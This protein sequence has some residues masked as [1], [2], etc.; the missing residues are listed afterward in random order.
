MAAASTAAPAVL[1]IPK[2]HLVPP[3]DDHRAVYPLIIGRGAF[4]VVYKA[5]YIGGIEPI[6][7]AVKK[8]LLSGSDMDAQCLAELKREGAIMS[9]T[10][11]P[12]I[13][14]CYGVVS[15]RL[16]PCLVLE[17]LPKSLWTILHDAHRGSALES[18][19]RFP[20]K[21]RLH[22]AA[23]IAAGMN[24][25]HNLQP[26]LAHRDLKAANVLLDD[27][28]NPK[29][30]D[31]GLS[32]I[33]Q[34]S[35]RFSTLGGTPHWMAPET[36]DQDRYDS[37]KSDSYA[38]GMT[39][40]ELYSGK[41]PFQDVEKVP[42]IIKRICD[43]I[44]PALIA[45][46]SSCPAA[47]VELMQRCWHPNPKMRP[48][49]FEIYKI[50]REWD[51]GS[52]PIPAPLVL[53]KSEPENIGSLASPRANNPVSFV[54]PRPIPASLSMQ[55]LAGV[56][57]SNSMPQLLSPR[58]PSVDN[59]F[60]RNNLASPRGPPSQ[61]NMFSTP[62]T[63]RR[64]P[65]PLFSPGPSDGFEMKAPLSTIPASVMGPTSNS[66][67]LSSGYIP[68]AIPTWAVGTG[69]LRLVSVFGGK[70]SGDGQF[71]NPLDI[72]FDSNRGHTIVADTENH[73][74]QVF[75]HSYKL[76][77]KVGGR[78]SGDGQLNSPSGVCVNSLGQIVV[79]DRE[80]H[81]IC[82]FDAEGRFVTKFG[83][84]GS[85][86]G[87]FFH[88]QKLTTDSQNRIYVCDWGNNRIQVCDSNGQY[89]YSFGSQGEANGRFR[90]P[91]CVAIN[92]K[93]NTLI[94]GDQYN[95]RL[96]VFDLTGKFLR[97]FGS[98]GRENSEFD[99]PHGIT[100]WGSTNFLLIADT[101]NH[102]V[103]VVDA[104]GRYISKL[105]RKGFKDGEFDHP[106][107]VAVNAESRILV[108]D[109]NNQRVQVIEFEP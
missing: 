94:V 18:E 82:I 34:E 19:R 60:S 11:H 102:R 96:Q 95:H 26:P 77:F 47:F 80:N 79:A 73:R 93:E 100:M 71:C 6:D 51:S 33:K 3:P 76:L 17:L 7:V 52:S 43:G 66:F 29:L 57:P 9:M 64:P 13:V 56:P 61:N 5:K 99:S 37:L 14:H 84:Q 12:N 68:S 103:H 55:Q 46:S 49:F 65:V 97:K 69:K 20:W 4:G 39:L 16:S 108:C 59:I 22:I 32:R 83:V 30:I 89:L 27:D 54:S 53:S 1:E 78:G 75:D 63:N 36:F 45:R 105:G 67:P 91:W 31:F 107:G 2:E 42:V 62:M 40:Y 23:G 101:R 24:Y 28:L 21:Q 109:T 44:R 85:F 92:P 35:A 106:A 41:Y 58:S 88:P 104:S 81:R 25:L 98:A 15:D 50:T 8:L 90:G 38:F 72:C 87:M 86:N 48:T 70:G 10:K 74:V